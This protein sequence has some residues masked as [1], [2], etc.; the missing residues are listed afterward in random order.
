[1]SSAF[2]WALLPILTGIGLLLYRRNDALPTYTAVS[3]CLFLTW[4]A[5]QLPIDVVLQLGP[6]SVEI[7]P[8]LVLFGRNFTLGEAERILLVLIY[9]AQTLWLL[10]A[11]FTRASRLFAPISMIAVGLFVAALSVEP[12][13][14]AALILAAVVL[15]FIP[16]LVEPGSAAGRGVQRFLKFQ[17]FAVPCILFTGWLLTGVEASPGNLN[18]VLRAGLLLAL[19]F[20]FLL[21]IFPFHAWLP[22]LAKESNPY[23]FGFLVFFLPAIATIFSLSFFD[24]YVWLRQNAGVYQLLL[25]AGSLNVLLGGLWAARERHLGRVF[26]FAAM[27]A[28][29]GLLQAIGAGGTLGVQA[30]FALLVPQALALWALA[31]G[32]AIFWREL[33]SLELADLQRS[34]RLHPLLVLSTMA[35]LLAIVGMPFLGPFSAHLA[36]WRALGERS[37]GLLAASLAGSLGLAA[38]AVRLLLAWLGPRNEKAPLLPVRKDEL[39]RSLQPLSD[40]AS[41]YTWIFFTGWALLLLGFGLLPRLFL[42]SVP[43]LAAMFPQLFP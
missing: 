29:G 3:L 37:V 13:L 17:M 14:Y 36:V 27:V 34:L 25:Y 32:L 24:R 26:A 21:A 38:A 2:L 35:S 1:M 5:W 41:P 23:V 30:F 39:G 18:L 6:F 8:N 19:G 10:G 11:V 22:L 16:L 4:V 15:V 12:F 28:T 40:M 20:G 33:K 43:S 31:V 7:A 9:L 42:G